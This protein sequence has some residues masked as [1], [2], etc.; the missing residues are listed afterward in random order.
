MFSGVTRG[1]RSL[2]YFFQIVKVL[3]VNIFRKVKSG[4]SFFLA[5]L[6][7]EYF[8]PKCCNPHEKKKENRQKF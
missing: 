6:R 7:G 4:M 1:R 2:E 3:D 8:A 5:V